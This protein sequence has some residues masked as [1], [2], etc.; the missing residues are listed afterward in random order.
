M[1]IRDRIDRWRYERESERIVVGGQVPRKVTRS[2]QRNRFYVGIALIL[3]LAAAV[4]G[5]WVEIESGA[6]AVLASALVGGLAASVYMAGKEA[7]AGRPVAIR[8]VVVL[9]YLVFLAAL[10][11]KVLW[12]G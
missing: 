1:G 4:M 10:G 8:A 3:L 5:G 2:S 12:E 6:R 11:I 7:S 9:A